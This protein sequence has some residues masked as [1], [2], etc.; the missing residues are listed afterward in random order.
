MFPIYT[1]NT[2]ILITYVPV[3]AVLQKPVFE[4][5]VSLGKSCSY[6]VLKSSPGRSTMKFEYVDQQIDGSVSCLNYRAD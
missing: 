5:T 6:C 3:V 4:V 2:Y 1:F